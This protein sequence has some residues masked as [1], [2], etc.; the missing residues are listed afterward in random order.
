MTRLTEL[1]GS[2]PL[3][4][5]ELD[6]ILL[7]QVRIEAFTRLLFVECGDG[8]IAEEAWRR[9]KKGYACGVDSS[10]ELIARAAAQRGVPGMLEFGTWDSQ[11]LPWPNGSFH[12][13]ISTFALERTADAISA[14]EEMRRVLRPGGDLYLLELDRAAG[15]LSDPDTPLL[16][17]ALGR[18]GFGKTRELLRREVSSNGLGTHVRAWRASVAA[19]PVSSRGAPKTS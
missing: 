4:R 2:E 12:L 18:A 16:L 8:W 13:V 6:L 11:R 10:P 5:R 17:S 1:N 14:L 7:D 15:L 9:T 3:L 19:P